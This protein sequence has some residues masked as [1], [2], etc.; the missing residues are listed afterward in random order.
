MIKSKIKDLIHSWEAFFSL[1]DPYIV[2]LADTP[3]V[4]L[5]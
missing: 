2:P 4:I 5:F 3:N 1:R